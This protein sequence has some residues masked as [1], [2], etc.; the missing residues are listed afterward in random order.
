MNISFTRSVLLA[1]VVSL[2][3]PAGAGPAGGIQPAASS[4]Y[5]AL[6]PGDQIAL[7]VQDI[8]EIPAKPIRIDPNGFIDLPLA[9]HIQASGLTTEQLKVEIAKRLKK[10]ITDPQISIDVAD[11][12]SRPVSVIGAVNTPGVHQLNGPKRLVEVIALAGGLRPDAGAK[13]ILT[14][15]SKNGPLSLPGARTDVSQGF[16]T[17]TLSLDSLLAAKNPAENIIVKPDDVIS[18]PKAEVVYV[19]GD[20]KKAGGFELHSH[21]TISLLQALSLA[22]GLDADAAPQKAKIL[23][24]AAEDASKMTEIP[25]DIKKILEG[26]VGDTQLYANDVLFVPNS[27]SKSSA[28]RAAEAVLQAAT[29]VAI[30][31]W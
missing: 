14:R 21:D 6:G 5:Y 16:S 24:P 7:E 15:E 23:R 26:K 31:H 1:A 13:V 22:E 12:E 27:L 30:Y 4:D 28:R 10:Y 20:V 3:V 17:A 8:D 29:G 18:I 11:Y 19:V 2:A 25:V 9:G